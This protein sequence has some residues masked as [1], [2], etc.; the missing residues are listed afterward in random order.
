[1]GGSWRTRRV[2]PGVVKL[3]LFFY[4]KIINIAMKIDLSVLALVI[5]CKCVCVE[6]N[7]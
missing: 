3:Q 2:S 1:M 4:C 6:Y 5:Y 7:L